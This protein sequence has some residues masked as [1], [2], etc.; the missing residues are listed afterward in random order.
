[1]ITDAASVGAGARLEY[2]V[3]IVGAGAA[4][5]SLALELE[6]SGA[7]VCML[8]AGG[9]RYEATVQALCD[10]EESGDTYPPL[11]NTRLAAFGGS[12]SVWAGWCRPLDAFDF[13]PRGWVPESGWP[14]GLASLVPDYR[15]A[16]ELCGLGPFE[17]R[18]EAWETPARRR[19][20]VDNADLAASIFHVS[21]VRFGE[22]YRDTLER[23]AA[24]T[25]LLHAPVLRC[26]MHPAADAVDSVRVGTLD[27]RQFDVAARIFILAGGGIDN[28]RLLL[29]SGDSPETSIGNAHGL[30]GRFFTDHAFIDP[31]ALVIDGIAPVLDFYYPHAGEASA[32]GSTVRAAFTLSRAALEREGLLGCAIYLHPPY[33]SHRVFESQEVQAVLEIWDGLRGR[34]VPGNH[35]SL[36]ATAMRRPQRP[37]H[38]LWRRIAGRYGAAARLRLRAFL[39]CGSRRENC[40]TLAVTKDALGRPLPRV[41]W[42]IGEQEARSLVRALEILDCAL[43]AARIGRIESKSGDDADWVRRAAVGG[44]HHMGTTR[45]HADPRRGVVDADARVHGIGNLYVAG[46]SV[47]PTGGYANPTLTI[48][49]LAVRLARHLRQAL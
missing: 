17:Y 32:A 31:G 15:R 2:D 21:R 13:E 38:A 24:I 22:R 8:E 14:F 41:E 33:A 12:T 10:G 23:S 25:V 29:L 5:I 45:M 42:R 1:M 43:K 16:H 6:G 48:V 11:R 34:A 7:R 20:P 27:G 39:E 28:A 49:A 44:K 37:M 40:V 36:L 19:L 3:C 46:S 26:R 9:L 18:P 47:F 30:V 35:W 4:G